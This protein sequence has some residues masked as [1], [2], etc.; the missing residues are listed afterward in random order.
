MVDISDVLG[1]RYMKLHF[2]LEVLEDGVLPVSKESAIRGG[3][4]EMLLCKNCL[5]TDKVCEQCEFEPE[6][7]VQRMFY[8]KFDIRPA[9]MTKGDS[10]GYV[11]ECEDYRK[12]FRIGD[13]LK[14]NILLFGKNIAYASQYIQSMIE[15]GK[16]GLGA[17]KLPFLIVE[18]KNT[19]GQILYDGREIDRSACQVEILQDYVDAR[20]KQMDLSAMQNRMIFHTPLTQKYQQQFLQ[21]FQMD[22][23]TKSIQRRLYILNCFEGRDVKEFYEKNFIAPAI[24]FQNV[25]AMRVKRYSNR[26]EKSMFFKGIKGSIQLQEISEDVLDLY[27]AGELIHIGKNTSFGFGRYT[28]R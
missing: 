27:L 24:I 3:I 9:F 4:G 16:N 22:A 15:L 7:I 18:I 19:K 13:R 6:C 17:R 1:I 8:S 11:I 23:I 10:V 21:E 26:Y 20:K 25:K 5:R 2:V 14:C 28:I 12:D